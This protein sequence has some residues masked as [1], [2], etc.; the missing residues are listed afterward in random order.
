M[1]VLFTVR[2]VTIIHK[3]LVSFKVGK[4]LVKVSQELIRC[5]DSLLPRCSEF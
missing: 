2:I 3:V 1:A 5:F 4:L